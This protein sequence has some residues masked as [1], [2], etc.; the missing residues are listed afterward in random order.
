MI[1]SSIG[2]AIGGVAIIALVVLGQRDREHFATIAELL[3]RVMA[4]RTA[5]VAILAFWWWLGWH[6][7]VAQTVDPAGHVAG[8]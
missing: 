5:R 2:F 1:L 4:T 7:L 6:F 8:R 3:D